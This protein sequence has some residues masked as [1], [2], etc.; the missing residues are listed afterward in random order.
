MRVYGWR[1]TAAVTVGVL[2]LLVALGITFNI[3]ETPVEE[4][5]SVAEARAA[6]AFQRGWLPDFLPPNA[7]HLREVHDIDTNQR[8]LTFTAPLPELHTLT[9]R[10][11]PLPYQAARRTAVDRPLRAGGAW[12]ME[13][14]KRFWHTP[15]ST[16]LLSYHFNKDDEYCLAIEWLTGRAWGWSCQPGG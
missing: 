8:W 2:M 7:T 6:G 9:L 10:F 12:P 15:R 16:R 5:A 3:I 4:Y 13:L 14:S 1:A 11:T